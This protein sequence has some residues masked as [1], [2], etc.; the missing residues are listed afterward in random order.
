MCCM[1]DGDP[2]PIMLSCIKHHHMG[3][4]ACIIFSQLH[5][6]DFVIDIH[7]HDTY[8]IIYPAKSS[9][10]VSVRVNFVLARNGCFKCNIYLFKEISLQQF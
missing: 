10:Q 9:A 8:N 3:A 2:L 5:I 4:Y 1:T 7:E 6:N